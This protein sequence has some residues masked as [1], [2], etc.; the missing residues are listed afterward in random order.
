MLGLIEKISL[1]S[2]FVALFFAVK[3]IL[4]TKYLNEKKT[5][6]IVVNP[7]FNSNIVQG[8]SI[9]YRNFHH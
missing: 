6:N 9:V 5:S 8:N 3:F 7:K 1:F 2:S 4:Y